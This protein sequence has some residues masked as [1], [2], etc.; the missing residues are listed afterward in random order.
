MVS[1][2]SGPK[3]EHSMQGQPL[4]LYPAYVQATGK[5][6]PH[7]SRPEMSD[8]N[9]WV[10][11]LNAENFLS[12]EKVNI[13]LGQL[14]VLV[15]LNASGKSNVV[16]A[17]TLLS[18]L[19]Q[20]KDVRDTSK[21]DL[22]MESIEQL[23]HRSNTDLKLGIRMKIDGH[24]LSYEISIS[25][26]AIISTEK[27]MLE[28]ETLLNRNIEG[29]V[30][31]F[32]DSEKDG[33]HHAP[34]S[35]RS[36]L[37]FLPDQS[38]RL[39]KEVKDIIDG[40]KTYSFTPDEVRSIAS[41]GFSLEL[42]RNGSNLAQVLHTLLTFDRKKFLVVEGIIRDLIPEIEEI[43]VPPVGSGENVCLA[44]REQ[45]IPQ[46]L[47]YSNISDGTLRVLAFTTALYVGGTVI[48]FEEPEN[49]V[50]P[51]LFETI[52]DLCRKAPCQ[53]ILTTHSPY[54]VNRV[55]PEELRLVTK[56]GGATRI[57]TV[58]DKKKVERMLEEG[59][60]LGEV[61]YSGELEESHDE[62]AGAS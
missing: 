60:P 51:Y 33:V 61:W 44:V 34:D 48:A 29:S 26:K 9:V 2:P 8:Q 59:L 1:P 53:V 32:T 16:R 35:Y 40:I 23:F 58:K 57:S 45:S 21:S 10:E 24:S 62:S 12:L 27:V 14:I 6:S 3:A 25:P 30:K 50:H 41:S 56:T 52:V 15:G 13:P 42:R 22:K 17:L 28:K 38:H 19:G 49:C 7:R 5:A 31:Y 47:R 54:L 46:P 11:E 4:C 20:P 55:P 36:I 39:I 18:K 37:A 43:N